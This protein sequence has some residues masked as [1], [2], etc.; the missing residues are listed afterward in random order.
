MFALLVALLSR[1]AYATDER[2]PGI[3]PEPTMTIK[4]TRKDRK[5]LPEAH[6]PSHKE[7]NAVERVPGGVPEAADAQVPAVAMSATL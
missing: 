3:R 7:D 6:Q 5:T 4:G 1:I 2:L